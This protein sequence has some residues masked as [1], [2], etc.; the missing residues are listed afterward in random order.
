MDK[1]KDI[2]EKAVPIAVEDKFLVFSFGSGR[3]LCP[4]SNHADHLGG[5][6]FN[7]RA[8]FEKLVPIFDLRGIE[9][10]YADIDTFIRSVGGDNACV[11][12]GDAEVESGW[13][14]MLRGQGLKPMLMHGKSFSTDCL[15]LSYFD[16]EAKQY[17]DS[18]IEAEYDEYC[19]KSEVASSLNYD[20]IKEMAYGWQREDLVDFLTSIH[21]NS[22]LVEFAMVYGRDGIEIVPYHANAVHNIETPRESI[23]VSRPGV[24]AHTTRCVFSSQ[25]QEFEQLINNRDTKERHLQDFLERNSNFLRGLNYQNI[26]PQLV[27]QRDNEG[28]LKPDF[29][30]EPYDDAFCDILEMKLPSQRLL[31]GRKDRRTFAAGVQEVVAQLREYASYFDDPKYQKY[32]LQKHGLRVYRPRLIALIGRDLKQMNEE[33]LRRAMTDYQNLQFMTFDELLEHSRNRMLL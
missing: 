17:V 3:H 6:I 33:Q 14:D 15:D 16:C 24:I 25:I 26:Y 4:H 22:L 12:L 30:L 7:L 18:A 1:F 11:F 9:G 23:L 10:Y 19:E 32:V 29:I 5:M 28:P 13:D 20:E 21:S 8:P 2:N 27:L 31:V